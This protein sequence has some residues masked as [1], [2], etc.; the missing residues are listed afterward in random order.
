MYNHTNV[1]VDHSDT[2]YSNLHFAA[3]DKG[4]LR[5][6][7][8]RVRD[9]ADRPDMAEKKRLWTLHNDLKGERPMVFCDPE[10]GWHEVIPESTLECSNDIARHWEL[11]LRKLLFWG[12]EMGDDYVVTSNFDVPHVYTEQPWRIRGKEDLSHGFRTQL[13]GGAYHIDSIME[14]YDEVEELLEP[15]IIVDEVNTQRVINLAEDVFDGILAV[16]SRTIW[17]WSFGLTDEFAQ[18]RGM[19]KM[20]MDFYDNPDGVHSL[21]GKLRDGTLNRLR[22]LE[23]K[24]LLAPN[25][26]ETYVGSGGLGFTTALPSDSPA[27]LNTMWGLGESQITVGVSPDMFAEFIFPYQKTIMDEFGLTCYGCCEGMENRIA[28]VKSCGNLRRVSIS[29]WADVPRMV[30][31]LQKGYIFSLKPTPAPL[32]LPEIDLD[33]A[34]AELEEKVG[35]AKDNTCL[36][37]IMKDNHTIGGNPQN[38]VRWVAL[39]RKITS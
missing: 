9:I 21:M 25:N 1:R 27:R 6:L 17:F 12:D 24:G 2:D 13:D 31:E 7:A 33:A 11:F 5:N 23:A 19:D 38:L 34:R 28:T 4:I 26:D 30:D 20:M 35:L 8:Y 15:K 14:T 37:V 39:A 16:R 22:F 10:H 29:H 36:E 32:A 18:I 3:G